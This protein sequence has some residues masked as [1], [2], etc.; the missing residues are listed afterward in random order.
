MTAPA[1]PATAGGA[2]TLGYV[3]LGLALAAVLVL[4]G[5]WLTYR[6]AYALMPALLAM[7]IGLAAIIVGGFGARRPRA[8]GLSIVGIVGGAVAILGAVV[9]LIV[10][11]GMLLLAIPQMM[12]A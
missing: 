3:S 11:L 12:G 10:W 5:P 9:P 7:P 6:G 4:A 2:R 8:R 1:V